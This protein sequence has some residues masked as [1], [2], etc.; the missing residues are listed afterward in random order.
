M[1]FFTAASTAPFGV[2]ALLLVA[3]VLLEA[4][5]LMLA[6]NPSALLDNLLPDGI[7]DSMLG[8]L[9]IGRVPVLIL[10]LLLLTGFS[11]GGYSLQQIS[12]S[13][14]GGYLSGGLASLAAL[15]VGLLSVRWFGT[16]LGRLVPRDE[17]SAVSEAS[18][19]GR[20]GL[21]TGGIA[22]HGMAAQALI[23]DHHGRPH[24]LMVEP[25]TD[26]EEFA[27]GTPIII[28]AKQGPFYRG[29]RDPQAQTILTAPQS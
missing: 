27:I 9:H 22:R 6:L 24:Y 15:P 10:L 14:T 29:I 3:L 5:G 11:L 12:L 7:G 16:A 21:I 2:A 13:L 23:K 8:W 18:F 28:V 17:T 26:G 19:I 4:I 20:G 25:D 1:D